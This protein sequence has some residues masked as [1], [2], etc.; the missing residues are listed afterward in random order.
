MPTQP[1][2]QSG[3]KIAHG[4]DE[5]IAFVAEDD[6]MHY[7]LNGKIITWYNVPEWAM[8]GIKKLEKSL[9]QKA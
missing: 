2:G 9:K 3:I 7:T 4:K 8:T 5:L 6:K 1:Y